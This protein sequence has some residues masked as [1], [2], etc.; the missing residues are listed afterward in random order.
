LKINIELEAIQW[1][2]NDNEVHE[3]AQ[4]HDHGDTHCFR[5]LDVG[6][7]EVWNYVTGVF[8]NLYRGDWIIRGIQEEFIV[9]S[10]N[11]YKDIQKRSSPQLSIFTDVE[12]SDEQ[13]RRFNEWFDKQ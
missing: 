5:K 12:I 7:A 4:H 6:K 8:Q 11:I 1:L 3:F 9:V 13:I 10:D 2:D